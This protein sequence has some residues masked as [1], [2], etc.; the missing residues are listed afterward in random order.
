MF[1]GTRAVASAGV[2]A[3]RAWSEV[4]EGVRDAAAAADAATAAADTASKLARGPQPL[5]AT[6]DEEKSVSELL[7]RRGTEV[8]SKADGNYVCCCEF[9]RRTKNVVNCLQK[10]VVDAD[11]CH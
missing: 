2:Q 1:A 7:K 5:L 4:A 8:L 6:A 11:Y 9:F 10:I 3:A